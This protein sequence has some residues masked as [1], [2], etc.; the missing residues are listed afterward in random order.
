M[1]VAALGLRVDGASNIEQAASSLDKLTKSAGSAE[2]SASSLGSSSS[3]AGRG[4]DDLSSRGGK[5]NGIIASVAA[6]M[7]RA[8]RSFVS[9]GKDAGSGSGG[10]DRL[11]KSLGTTTN[12]AESATKGLGRLFAAATAGLSA[13]AVIDISDTWGQYASRVKMATSSIEEYNYVQARMAASANDTYRSINET[14]EAFLNLSPVL[15]SMGYS[16]EESINAV[17][18]FS[19]LLVVN[20]ANA[21]RGAAAMSALSRSLQKG[22]VDADA[23]STIYSTADT[24]VDSLAESTGKTAEEIRKL[25]A[26]GKLSAQQVAAALA[27]DY[28]RVMAQVAEMPTTVRDAMRN[29][30]NSFSEMV[31]QVNQASQATAG[32]AEIIDRVA[33]R[34]GSPEFISGA[35]EGFVAWKGTIAAVG[36]DIAELDRILSEFSGNAQGDA[37]DISFSFSEMPANIRAMIQIATVEIASFIDAQMNGIQALAAAVKALPDGPSAAVDAFNEVRKQRA[38][39]GQIRLESI[40]QILKERDTILQAGRDAANSYRETNRAAL[41]FNATATSG[42]KPVVELTKEQKK[43]AKTLDDLIA[44][45]AV[46]TNSAVAMAAAYNSGAE[47]VRALVIEQKIEEELLKTGAKSREAVTKAVTSQQNAMDALDMAKTNADIRQQVK[48]IQAQISVSQAN[49]SSTKLGTAAQRAYNIEKQVTAALAGKNAD[50]LG[51]ETTELRK[52]LGALEDSRIKLEALGKLDGLIDSTATS[53][54]KLNKRLAE[55]GELRTWATT[56]EQIRAIDRAMREAQRESS[57]WAKFT[58]RAVDS[59]DQS[60]ADMWKNIDGGFGSFADGLKNSFKNL[61]AELAH[62]AITRPI[63]MQFASSLGIGGIQGQGQGGGLLGGLGSLFGGGGG[64]STGG[65]T[66]ALQQANQVR[67]LYSTYGT[68]QSLLPALQGGWA[69]GGFGG[70][71]G[72]GASTLGGMFGLGSGAA[73]SMAAGSTAAGYGGANFAAW[74]AAQGGASAAGGAGV[75]AGMLSS[76]ASA[77]PLAVAMGIWQSG[78]LYDQGVRPDAGEMWGS[79]QGNALGKIGNVAPTAMSGFYKGLDSVLEPVVGGKVAAMITGSTFH[80]ALWGGINKALFGGAWQTKDFG[81]G[82]GI[83]D[84]GLDAQQFEYRKKKGGLFSSSKKKTIWSELDPEVQSALDDTYAAT[85]DGVFSLFES[86]SYTIEDNALAGLNMAR[87]QISTQGKTEEEI[88]TAIAE[89]FGKA[90]NAMTTEL[91]A[92]FGTGLALDFAGMQAFVGNLKGV[93]EVIRYL[94]VDMFDM[95]VAGGKLAEQLS[96]IAGGLD[97][98]AGGVST[99]Y[100]AFFTEQEKMDDTLDSITRTFKDAD[101]A[102]ATNREAYRSMVEDIDLTTV[103]GQELFATLMALSGQAASYYDIL[104]SRASTALQIAQAAVIAAQQALINTVGSSFSLVQRSI[105]AERDRLTKEYQAAVAQQQAAAQQTATAAAARANS[106]ND[107]AATSRSVV[108]SLQRLD[109]SLQ[110]ALDKLLDMSSQSVAMRREE[111]LAVLRNAL[112]MGQSGKSLSGFEGIEEALGRASTLDKTVYGTLADFEREQGRTA[113]LVADLQTINGKQLTAE[114]KLLAQLESSYRAAQ[115]NASALSSGVSGISSQLQAEYEASMARLDK[116]LENAQAQIDALNGVDNSILSVGV[117]I[118]RMNA[119]IVAAINGQQGVTPGIGVNGDASTIDRLYQSILG[120]G[121]DSEGQKFWQNAIA[122]NVYS[123]GDLAAA[124][125]A[126]AGADALGKVPAFA[127]GG[128]FTNGVVTRPTAFNMG[129]MGESGSEGILPL[130][131]IGGRLGVHAKMGGNDNSEIQAVRQE[132]SEM[133]R[134]LEEI[135]WA[136]K[137]TESATRSM[138]EGGVMIDAASSRPVV[139]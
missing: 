113:N 104:E 96:G 93:N 72:A 57:E 109:G 1:E 70:A 55:L 52:Q 48:D 41:E 47:S 78:K 34:I 126:Q 121:A 59:V 92:V 13:M 107:M 132:L 63:I 64:T 106:L 90:A 119:S 118:D 39:L 128:A 95:T 82:L 54:E 25:G 130:A 6:S 134:F 117:A 2:K 50:A 33:E 11:N 108:Q 110:S 38:V 101:V 76:M 20:G 37:S 94:N 98:L 67:S 3:K 22:K 35:I 40:E 133:K 53:Q 102:L 58:E 80:Q 84:G 31:G 100:G 73:G 112:A 116:E 45:Y 124:L 131:N 12:Q 15:R 136:S 51:K 23:W 69:S 4:L 21:E 77:W 28:T 88:Q 114:E 66:G 61:L 14:R 81:L 111:S 32:M 87:E 9:A 18:T 97:A 123:Y 129:L 86:L 8:G 42:I 17:D 43:A 89:W 71:F 7:N 139:A 79:T 46:A 49:T 127:N 120:Y 65:L 10:V 103:A 30:G 24:I 16:L 27:G 26:A 105:S 62:M 85:A 29:V 74:S 19:G 91:Q 99:Y 68:V 5:T 36:G 135:M 115:S 75:G 138:D 137:G 125:R 56:P 122:N 83:E 60:F 44:K